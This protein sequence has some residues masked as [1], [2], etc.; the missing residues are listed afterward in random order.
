MDTL[1]VLF[2][3]TIFVSYTFLVFFLGFQDGH[4]VALEEIDKK[5]KGLM[6]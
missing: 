4:K 6:G 2:C 5:F 3:I 1:T